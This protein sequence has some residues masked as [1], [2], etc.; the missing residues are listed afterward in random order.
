MASGAV[1][2]GMDA[3]EQALEVGREAA[4]GLIRRLDDKLDDRRDPEDR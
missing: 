3:A 2:A 4:D 1:R